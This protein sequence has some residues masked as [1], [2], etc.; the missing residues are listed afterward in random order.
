[1]FNN[2]W[3]PENEA[4]IVNL[5]VAENSLMV[6]RIQQQRVLGIAIRPDL[7]SMEQTGRGTHRIL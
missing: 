4:G 3:S 2:T 5:G 7:A 6:G 1:M